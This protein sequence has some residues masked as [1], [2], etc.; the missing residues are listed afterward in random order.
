RLSAR[1]EDDR[2]VIEV[3]DPGPG[4]PAAI[5]DRIFDPFFTTKGVGKGL[6]LGLSISYNIIKDFG[7]SLSV[8]NHADGGAVFRIV[9]DVASHAREAAE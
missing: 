6:G 2:V 9:L 4:V 3:R 5:A 7:G 8:T 1:R